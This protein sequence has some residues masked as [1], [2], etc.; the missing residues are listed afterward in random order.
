MSEPDGMCA[1]LRE[2]E[3]LRAEIAELKSAR[4]R[5]PDILLNKDKILGEPPIS[6][7]HARLIE[8]SGIGKP[9]V[10]AAF[11]KKHEEGLQPDT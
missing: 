9:S 1:A 8:L 6:E 5:G 4:A 10:W 11:I 2:M 7:R 3:R